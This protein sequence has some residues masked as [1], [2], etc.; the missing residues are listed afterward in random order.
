MALI[1]RMETQ[2]VLNASGYT[3]GANTVVRDSLRAGKAIDD[4]HGRA[5]RLGAGLGGMMAGFGRALQVALGAVLGVGA[6]FVGL[7]IYAVKAATSF[8]TL[9]RTLTAVTGSAERARAILAFVDELA[10]P[11]V[12]S[13][14]VLAGAAKTL[15]AFG[16]RAERYLP[17][18]EK[19]GTVFGGS[20]EKL[21]QF[22]RALGFIKG[23]RFGEAFE[24]LAAAGI[25]RAELAGKGLQFDKGGQFLGSVEDALDAVEQLVNEKY[26]R[27]ADEMASGPAARLASLWDQVQRGVR[28]AGRAL[29]TAFLPYLDMAAEKVGAWVKDGTFERIGKQIASWFM[30]DGPVIK[31]LI[32]FGGLIDDIVHAV[33]MIQYNFRAVGNAVIYVI[34]L[35]TDLYNKLVDFSG[36][37]GR[38]ADAL[39]FGG[40]VGVMAKLPKLEYIDNPEPVR[41]SRFGD[42]ARSWSAMMAGFFKPEGPPRDPYNGPSANPEAGSAVPAALAEVASNTAELVSIGKRQLELQEGALGGGRVGRIGIAAREMRGIRRRTAMVMA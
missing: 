19:L 15:E 1:D 23:G 39:G 31:G 14:E 35:A 28:V 42:M 22:V 18:V 20:A 25:T 37:L 24:A 8:D 6:A 21:D 4:T 16:L 26:G 32:W 33:N 3:S 10:I 7:G 40:L 34:N 17:I 30:P 41:S 27:L 38:I 2:Y 12:F 36:L 11:S 13:T 9:E 29:L 5:R